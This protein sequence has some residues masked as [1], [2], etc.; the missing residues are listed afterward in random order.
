[1][2]TWS[3]KCGEALLALLI[4]LQKYCK[5]FFLH[6]VWI[7]K[8]GRSCWLYFLSMHPTTLPSVWWSKLFVPPWCV[9]TLQ[10]YKL[11]TKQLR[12]S[13]GSKWGAQW[14]CLQGTL[15]SWGKT[16]FRSSASTLLHSTAVF[17][18]ELTLDKEPSC[19]QELKSPLLEK[20]CSFACFSTLHDIY[21]LWFS[22]PFWGVLWL[23]FFK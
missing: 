18:A 14:S 8:N 7:V 3:Q 5:G 11:Q 4:W 2:P 9:S 19:S 13:T 23:Q 20:L 21:L 22:S 10:G 1:M 6:N 15:S 16:T 17:S 12:Y